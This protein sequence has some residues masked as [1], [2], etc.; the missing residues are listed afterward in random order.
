MTSCEDGPQPLGSDDVPGPEPRQGW[1]HTRALA[2]LG[3]VFLATGFA[4]ALAGPFLTLFLTSAAHANALQLSVFLI[5]QPVCGIAA[6]SLMG[7]LSDGRLQRRHVLLAASIGGCAGAAS[8]ATVRNYWLLLLLGCTVNAMAGAVMPQA[9]AHAH[10]VLAGDPAAAMLTSTL[11]TFFSLAWVAGPPLAA[12]L[13]GAGGFGSLYAGAAVLYLV[14]AAVAAF[15]L[16]GPREPSDPAAVAGRAPR[17]PQARRRSL[18]LTL[19]GLV[20]CQSSLALNV[21]ALP[22]HVREDLHGGVRDAG[23][24][25]GLCAALEIPAMLGFGALSRRVP[26]RTLIRL[27]PVVGAGYFTLA[28]AATQ[29]W[30]LAVAQLLNACYIAV[31]GGLAISYVQE[32]VPSQPGRASTLYSNTFPCGA[33]LAGPLLGLAVSN[34]YRMPYVAGVGLAI[35]AVVLISAGGVRKARPATEASGLWTT[36]SKDRVGR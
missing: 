10:T 9:F 3:V 2:P 15:W 21:Q 35:A 14:V 26:L 34:G 18:W 13:L 16:K 12:L 32:L 4:T 6:S 31:I 23:M 11:R 27:G 20:A 17:P 7:R 28:A 30:Q 24:I 8:F 5:A 1:G 25:L 33:I 22:L 29:V 36:R 19:V